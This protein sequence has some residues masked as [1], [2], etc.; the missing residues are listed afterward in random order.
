LA[1]HTDFYTMDKLVVVD[2]EVLA[3][4]ADENEAES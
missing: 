3:A 2:K 4:V 1:A